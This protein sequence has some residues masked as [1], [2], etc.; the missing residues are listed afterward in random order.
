VNCLCKLSVI[1]DINK[2]EW[3]CVFNVVEYICIVRLKKV[4]EEAQ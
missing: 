2:R 4:E 3:V 1:A